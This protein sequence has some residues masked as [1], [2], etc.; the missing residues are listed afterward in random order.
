MDLH[1]I[2]VLCGASFGGTSESAGFYLPIYGY[3]PRSNLA[4]PTLMPA[5]EKT[6]SST[7]LRFP[8]PKKDATG[9]VGFWSWTPD[10]EGSWADGEVQ[11]SDSAAAI[12]GTSANRLQISN[13][14][15]LDRFVHPDDRAMVEAELAN[16]ATFE[17]RQFYALEYRIIRVDGEVRTIL[18]LGTNVIDGSGRVTYSAGTIQDLLE[19]VHTDSGLPNAPVWLRCLA[20]NA[21]VSFFV[22]DL[23]GRYQFV[24]RMFTWL[25]DLPHDQV[26]GKT[27]TDLYGAD[28][29]ER[30]QSQDRR[31]LQTLSTI[32]EEV[33]WPTP[34]GER[35][36]VMTKF[37]ILNDT[38]GAIGIGCI[39]EDV[40]DLKRTVDQLAASNDRF[41]Q[42]VEVASDW[43][44]E[45]GADH[46]FTYISARF[47]DVTG[48]SPGDLLGHRWDELAETAESETWC[49]HREDLEARRP[50]RN[51]SY[52]F[53]HRGVHRHFSVS[54]AP[55]F[56]P[57]GWFL[58]YRGTGTDITA[59]IE[60][61]EKA[62]AAHDHLVELAAHLAEAKTAAE[63]ANRAKSEFLA[64]MSHELRTPLNAIIGFSELL[65]EKIYGPLTP[66]QTDYVET[67]HAA[68][69]HLLQII[70]DVLDLSKI[71]AGKLELR[72]HSVEIRSL[73]ESCV[74]LIR[75]RAAEAGLDL[76]ANLPEKNCFVWADAVRLKQIVINILSN[77]VKFTPRGGRVALWVQLDSNQCLRISIKD[78]GIG[79]TRNEV[80]V[81]L[82]PFSQLEQSQC[83]SH[84]GTGL[85]LPLARRLTEMHGGSLEI[86]STP[87]AGTTVHIVL[88]STRLK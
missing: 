33:T 66:R 18:E 45:T 84:D 40:T 52:L 14:E 76:V 7:V 83:R 71:E 16:V 8:G 2:R 39:E 38:G 9:R 36:F 47:R 26:I 31:V 74:A 58:G 86:E 42:I 4:D 37:P 34:Q 23:N 20:E 59:Q 55:V 41:R 65:A 46:R 87:G 85:G 17:P 69:R 25:N 63:L 51:F 35:T 29:V 81:A 1:A 72:E 68:G 11:Y 60:A 53:Q 57:A 12:L 73:L 5:A 44:W 21:P 54:G 28:A 15:Y 50:F 79:M 77:A 43:I 70:A 3:D 19:K 22:K 27:A 75:P 30:F 10:P 64:N 88:P 80:A 56:S 82:E 78:T 13:R 6:P 61:E 48:L 62:R 67:I 32:Q 24:N 49:R